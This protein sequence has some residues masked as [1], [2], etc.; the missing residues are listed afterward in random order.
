MQFNLEKSKVMHVDQNNPEYEY[1]MDGTKL[2]RI[3]EEKDVGLW[4]TRI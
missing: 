4:I 2:T 1:Q 3:E